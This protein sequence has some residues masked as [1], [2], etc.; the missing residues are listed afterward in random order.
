MLSCKR[1]CL[2]LPYFRENREDTRK[3]TI[4]R[5]AEHQWFNSISGISWKQWLLLQTVAQY[6]PFSLILASSYSF[7]KGLRSFKVSEQYVRTYVSKGS[8]LSPIRIPP[9]FLLPGCKATEWAGP[10]ELLLASPGLWRWHQRKN[11]EERNRTR[12]AGHSRREG[13][14]SKGW[15]DTNMGKQE[16]KNHKNNT[17]KIQQQ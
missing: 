9:F 5:D 6:R 1:Y 12:E 10:T 11:Q 7:R 13:K 2:Q 14:A 15:R 3:E 17:V 8:S 16:S 4:L